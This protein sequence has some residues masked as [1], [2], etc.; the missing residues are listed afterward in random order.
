MCL[1]FVDALYFPILRLCNMAHPCAVKL[2]AI[3]ASSEWLATDPPNCPVHCYGPEKGIAA[4][5][6]WGAFARVA[7]VSN[8]SKTLVDAKN[9]T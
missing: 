7:L 2:P 4:L 1:G 9:S 8:D 3:F 5:L 6:L